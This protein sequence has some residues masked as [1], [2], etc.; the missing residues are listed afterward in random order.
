IVRNDVHLTAGQRC[1]I[2]IEPWRLGAAAVGCRN[3][4]VLP[5]RLDVSFS[6]HQKN[7]RILE[8]LRQA[9]KNLTGMLLPHPTA[10]AVRITRPKVLR[11]ESDDLIQQLAAFIGVVVLGDDTFL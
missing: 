5:E 4:A 3:E 6:L 9:V 2:S 10:A 8:N 7:D 11:L 1:G